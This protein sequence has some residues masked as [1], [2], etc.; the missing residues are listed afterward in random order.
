MAATLGWVD[1]TLLG[2]LALSVVVGLWRGLVFE[3]MSLAGW[4]VAYIGAQWWSPALAPHVPLGTSG[5]PLQQALAFAGCFLGVL[6]AWSLLSRLVRLLVRA[7]PLT[8][9]DRLLGAGFGLLRGGVLLL[10]LCTVVA[11]TPA[12]QASAWQASHGAAWTTQALQ[13]LKPWLPAA[14]AT[15]LPG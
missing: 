8:V 5:S 2:L 14:M 12:A 10:A 9:L 11:M 1:L 3:V 15:H 7:T 4:L 6:V 13:G